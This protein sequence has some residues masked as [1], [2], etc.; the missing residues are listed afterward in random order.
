MVRPAVIIAVAAA[1]IGCVST[2]P[3]EIS[4]RLDTDTGVT[5]ITINRPLGFAA[6]QRQLSTS[7]RDYAYIGPV[8][9]NRMG[10]REHFLWVG[11]ASTIDRSLAGLTLP[12]TEAIS[13]F[14]DGEPMVLSLKDWSTIGRSATPYNP[15]APVVESLGVAVSVDQIRLITHATTLELR[16]HTDN[17][18]VRRFKAWGESRQ[19]WQDFLQ[20][21]AAPSV[22]T[23]ATREPR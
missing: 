5:Y 12:G 6:S 11:V 9:V 15:P 2:T 10:S 22:R 3:R 21:I 4:S 1:L 19:A 8:Q 16:L 20:D 18:R 7:A 14:I 23:V 13:L 17:N